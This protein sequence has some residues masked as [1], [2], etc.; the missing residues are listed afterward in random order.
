MVATE[1]RPWSTGELA[2]RLGVN[3]R[4]VAG[5]CRDGL[6]DTCYQTPAGRWRIDRPVRLDGSLARHQRMLDLLQGDDDAD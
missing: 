6:V 5:W 1:L 4:T 3:A 2:A